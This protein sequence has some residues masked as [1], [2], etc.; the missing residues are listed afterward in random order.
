MELVLGRDT[1][2]FGTH[3]AAGAAAAGS[4]SRGCAD[5]EGTEMDAPEAGSS[6]AGRRDVPDV[7]S[8]GLLASSSLDMAKG[9]RVRR[10]RD[11]AGVRLLTMRS[12]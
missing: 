4:A 3:T 2:M 1:S 12:S 5:E 9:C 10:A 7:G 6:V 8:V 11:E